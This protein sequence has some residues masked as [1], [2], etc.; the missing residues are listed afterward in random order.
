MVSLKNEKFIG[1][2]NAM[3]IVRADIYVDTAEELPEAYNGILGKILAQG[4]TALDISSGDYYC[5]SGSGEWIN[6]NHSSETDF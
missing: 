6:Q 5:L 2:R 4:S 3:L 1:F